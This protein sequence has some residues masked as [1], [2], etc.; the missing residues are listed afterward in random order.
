MKKSLWVL[1][2]VLGAALSSPVW[3]HESLEQKQCTT[4][5]ENGTCLKSSESD[6]DTCPCPIIQKIMKKAHFFLENKDEMGLSEE[7]VTKIKTIKMD[8][9][10]S[11]IHMGADMQIFEMDLKSKLDESNMDVEGIDAMID[12]SMAGMSKSA[13]GS[14]QAY[15][16]LKAILTDDQMA[17]AKEIW[18]KK[19]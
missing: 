10:K 13:K 11:A 14:V 17:K 18:K 12:E 2:F 19:E 6:E 3:A 7:Q 4:G 5:R 16:D 8:A 9:K 1:L 15:A